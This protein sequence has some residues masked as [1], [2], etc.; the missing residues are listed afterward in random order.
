MF[1]KQYDPFEE[2]LKSILKQSV[3]TS[4]VLLLEGQKD[5]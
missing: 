4:H 5:R 1:I 2:N 3:E